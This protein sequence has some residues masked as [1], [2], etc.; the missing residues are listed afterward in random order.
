MKFRHKSNF[1]ELEV[2]EIVLE[3][4]ADY[5]DPINAR[6]LSKLLAGILLKKDIESI[7]EEFDYVKIGSTN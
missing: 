4:I 2:L 6:K 3:L 5:Y 7:L 1:I